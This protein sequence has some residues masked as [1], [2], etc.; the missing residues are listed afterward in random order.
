MARKQEIEQLMTVTD[1][2]GMRLNATEIDISMPNRVELIEEA[3]KPE[4]SDQLFRT[5]LSVL[6]SIA[7]LV[8]GGGSVVAFDYV[9]DRLSTVEEPAQRLGLRVVG[10]VPKI[11]RRVNPANVAECVD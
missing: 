7:G 8:L 5:M 6:A 2:M 3:S 11:T 9:Q 10:T 1:D 4:G